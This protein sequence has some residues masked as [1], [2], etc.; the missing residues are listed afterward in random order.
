VQINLNDLKCRAKLWMILSE[1]E[2][3]LINKIYLSQTIDFSGSAEGVIF[4]KYL[5]KANASNCKCLKF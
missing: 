3:K 5:T 4:A 1:G 2:D